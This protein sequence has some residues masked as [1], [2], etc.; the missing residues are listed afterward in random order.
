MTLSWLSTGC[1]DAVISASCLS[2]VPHTRSYWCSLCGLLIQSYRLYIPLPI[3]WGMYNLWYSGDR[4]V[5]HMSD[6]RAQTPCLGD[7]S[8]DTFFGETS[9]L[10]IA[11]YDLLHAP[12]PCALRSLPTPCASPCTSCRSI[13]DVTR[14]FN[15]KSYRT[16][17][18]TG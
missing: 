4:S 17:L 16:D 13:C 7:Q 18:V 8:S 15:N 12:P 5:F 1:R 6:S 9:F 2:K 11:L 14:S 10:K 3:T